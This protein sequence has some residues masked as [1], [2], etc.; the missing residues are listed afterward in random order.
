MSHLCA[1]PWS[2]T[3][4]K[5]LEALMGSRLIPSVRCCMEHGWRCVERNSSGVGIYFTPGYQGGQASPWPWVRLPP[6]WSGKRSSIYRERYPIG[7]S[8]VVA[9][10][11]EVAE[12]T[13]F[14]FPSF[15][16]CS[17]AQVNMLLTI[18]TIGVK[19]RPMC[20]KYDSEYIL[21]VGRGA[22]VKVLDFERL[23]TFC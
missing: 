13:K 6:V 4:R 15:I 19:G 3:I 21:Y 14:S 16:V 8:L 18:L 5:Q 12:S 11:S 10:H 17:C 2:A 23:D 7:P 20:A 9:S 1:G 22:I